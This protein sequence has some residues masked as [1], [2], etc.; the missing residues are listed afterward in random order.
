MNKLSVESLPETKAMP[1][2]KR[3][4]EEKG[5][6]VQI[7]HREDIRHLAFFELKKGF[8]RGSHVHRK[9]REVFYVLRGLMKGVFIDLATGEQAER[10]LEK[11]TKVSMEPGLAHILY[12][13]EDTHVVEYGSEYY[14]EQDAVAVDFSAPGLRRED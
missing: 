4:L 11:G 10:L 9:K 12:G 14:D 7:S 1:G 13:I 5:E 3:W 6:F 2:A 8:W